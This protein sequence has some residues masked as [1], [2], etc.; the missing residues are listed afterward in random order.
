MLV[1]VGLEP[2]WRIVSIQ[3]ASGSGTHPSP[4]HQEDLDS[5][6]NSLRLVPQQT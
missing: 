6:I 4:L 2:H 3:F 1:D 5:S